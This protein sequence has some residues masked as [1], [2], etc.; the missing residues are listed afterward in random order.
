METVQVSD[1]YRVTIPESI[2]REL[3]LKV[4]DELLLERV[5]EGMYRFRVIEKSTK[6][7]ERLLQLLKTP[8]RRT[9]EPKEASPGEMRRLEEPEV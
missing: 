3:A 1:R 4:G 8:P 2:R 5:A 7:H 9:G 6:Y